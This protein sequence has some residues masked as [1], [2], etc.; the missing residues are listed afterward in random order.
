MK[1]QRG[2][3]YYPVLANKGLRMYVRLGAQDVE[4]RLWDDNDPS[5]WDEH[6]WAPYPAILAAAEMYKKEGRKGGPPLELYDIDIAIR[7]LKDEFQGG[8]DG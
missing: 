8:L 1:D 4:F 7:L 5:L 3:Y 6:G 2:I